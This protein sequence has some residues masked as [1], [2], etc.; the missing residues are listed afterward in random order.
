MPK[1]N[2]VN[3]VY[4]PALLIF[5]FVEKTETSKRGIRSAHVPYIFVTTVNN[6]YSQYT[7]KK[8][9]KQTNK[10]LQSP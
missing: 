8:Q 6:I 3:I 5:V 2:V 7:E 1:M 4:I 9:K 10:Q